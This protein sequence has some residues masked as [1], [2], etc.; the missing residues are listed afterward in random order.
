MGPTLVLWDVDNTMIVNGGVSKDAYAG[1]FEALT[2]MRVEHRP[3]TGGS[4]DEL[5]M[6]DLA[7]LH[8]VSLP[9]ETDP[10]FDALEH[11]LRDRTAD[12]AA[13]GHAL[14]GTREALDAL[15]RVAGVVQSVLTGNIRPNAYRKLDTFGLAGPPLE[16]GI[17]AFGSDDRVRANL[18]GIAQRRAAAEHGVSFTRANTVLVGDTPNDVRAGL[19]GGAKVVAV[20]TGSDRAD[21]LAEV[22]A[23]IVLPSLE[24]T[25]AFLV[26]FKQ[27][28]EA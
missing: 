17:G 22:G 19:E 9:A 4:T 24:D 25:A 18:V 8:G 26:A 21:V 1:A 6:R 28:L 3:R 15:A 7:E 2:G 10:I 27:V 13:R 23:D 11:S 16:W 5:I 20:A 14:P 12:L